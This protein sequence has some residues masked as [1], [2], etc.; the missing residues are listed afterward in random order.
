MARTV[1]VHTELEAI[2]VEQALPMA[3]ELEAVTDAAPDGAVLAAGEAAAL[4]LGREL[5][6]RALEAAMPRRNARPWPDR[7]IELTTCLRDCPEWALKTWAADRPSRAVVTVERL[8]KP[9]TRVL[10]CRNPNSPRR[11]VCLRPGQEGLFALPRQEFGLD[12]IALAGRLRHAERLYSPA[13]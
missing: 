10:S 13:R 11:E 9:R 7:T 12:V 3:R 8:V 5:T 6:R 2:L 1:E 4:R